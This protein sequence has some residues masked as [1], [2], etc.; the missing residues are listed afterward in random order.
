M[1]SRTARTVLLVGAPLAAVATFMLGLRVGAGEA[2]R[3]ASIFAAP[4]GKPPA[5]G[6]PTPLALQIL[7]YYEERS[8]RETIAMKGL[9]LVARSKGKEARWTGAS[10]ADGIAEANLAIEGFSKGDPLDVELRVEGEREPLAAGSIASVDVPWGRS[11]SSRAA[12][13]PAKR[14]GPIELDVL[15]EGERLVPGFETSLWIHASKPSTLDLVPEPGLRLTKEHVTTCDGG[16]AEAPAIAEGHVV[17]IG[18]TAHASELKGEWFGPL[19]VAP[20]AFFV[21]MPRV[22]PENE[23]QTIVLVAPNPR[24]VVYAEVDDERGRVAAAALPVA[25]DPGD[26]IPRARFALPPLAKG[27]HWLVVSGEPRG[28]EHLAGAAIA[29]PFVVG[30]MQDACTVGP[31]L[32][33]APAEG[34]PRWLALDGMAVRGATNRSR[35]RLGL[36][37]GLL[38]LVSAAAIDV[39][40]LIA[41]AREARA[42]ML[43]ADLDD[44]DAARG[45]VT[46]KPPGGSLAIAL[47]L[48]VLGFALLAVLLFVKG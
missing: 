21:G 48:A 6:A 24:H 15:V 28:A 7:T 44:P 9:V 33:Q 32:A 16:W 4:P 46:A 30:P 31:M 8:V 26:A 10:N 1:A 2:V 18:V 14:T 39:L 22:V 17:G 43:L 23:A 19:P 29:K 37:I 42:A 40:L 25:L 38:A 27:L 35:H 3:S 36:F 47:L 13:R 20:G 45:R 34:F 12:A 11:S 41:A 5:A